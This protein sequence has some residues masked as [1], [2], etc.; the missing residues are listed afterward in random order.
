M[1]I[2]I[3]WKDKAV[4]G[5]SQKIVSKWKLLPLAKGTTAPE[6]QDALWYAVDSDYQMGWQRK[7]SEVGPG[8]ITL[9]REVGF[10]Q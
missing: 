5:V 1:A 7:D 2:A 4:P 3:G 9:A 10:L 8:L 6:I